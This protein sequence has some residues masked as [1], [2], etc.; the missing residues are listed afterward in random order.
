[1][2]R[3]SLNYA[4]KS[5]SIVIG[6]SLDWER[7]NVNS[8]RASKYAPRNERDYCKPLNNEY[9]VTYKRRANQTPMEQ[10]GQCEYLPF[11]RSEFKVGALIRMNVHESDFKGPSKETIVQASQASTLVEGTQGGKR[12]KE[13]RHHGDFGPIYSENRICIVVHV[14]KSIYSAIP[15]Y[16]HAGKGLASIN[17]D[18]RKEWISIQDHR[19]LEHGPPQSEHPPLRTA[20]MNPQTAVLSAVSVAWIPYAMPC[21]FDVPVAYQGSLDAVSAERL[22]RLYRTS[23]SV[24]PQK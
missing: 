23:L 16:T 4:E 22:V 5:G 14:A 18:E 17:L 1:M 7:P 20:Y 11:H 19:Q 12:R 24:A 13:H 2:T 3:L 9:S 21:R 10:A 15:L 8:S 6:R